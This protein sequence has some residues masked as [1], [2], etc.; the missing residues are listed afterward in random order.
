MAWSADLSANM[1]VVTDGEPTVIG[2]DD[3]GLTFGSGYPGYLGDG[4]SHVAVEH[5]VPNG[6]LVPAGI[7]G[8]YNDSAGI[9]PAHM[10]RSNAMGCFP[11][12]EYGGVPG[13]TMRLAY[14][15]TGP[16]HV[17]TVESFAMNG[18][19]IRPGRP[20]LARGGPVGASGDLGQY[21]AVAMAQ[22]TYDFPAQDLSQLN[23]LLGLC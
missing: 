12:V 14:D 1:H 5:A 22:S 9:S 20:E 8:E 2:T 16:A 3:T 18:A 23:V 10:M 4:S 21:L 7:L 13:R 15:E 6:S 19:R 17:G 11:N